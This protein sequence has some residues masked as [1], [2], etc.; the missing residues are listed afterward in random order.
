MWDI[1]SLLNLETEITSNLT[2]TEKAQVVGL[3]SAF[4]RTFEENFKKMQS[5]KCVISGYDLCVANRHLSPEVRR[6]LKD[7]VKVAPAIKDSLKKES[8]P[9]T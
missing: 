9:T 4:S 2:I 5:N 7:I 6:H 1:A 3:L 8:T